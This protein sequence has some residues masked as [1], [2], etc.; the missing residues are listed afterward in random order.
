MLIEIDWAGTLLWIY[1]ASNAL[2]SE[3]DDSYHG[4]FRSPVP[5]LL[6]RYRYQ[7]TKA[8]GS[9][10]SLSCNQ[11]RLIRLQNS[12]GERGFCSSLMLSVD[13]AHA[14]NNSLDVAKE[15]RSS[16]LSKAQTIPCCH[17]IIC[18][19]FPARK[20][21]MSDKHRRRLILQEEAGEPRCCDPLWQV[22][23]TPFLGKKVNEMMI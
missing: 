9:A 5:A 15:H 17:R 22:R 1:L 12:K 7:A 16:L 20:E 21:A 18:T 2:T 4:A 23:L 14:R 6:E 19:P 3:V 8:D 11:N 10:V 13:G